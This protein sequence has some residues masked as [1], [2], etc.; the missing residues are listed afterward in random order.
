MWQ[1]SLHL[2]GNS[3]LPCNCSSSDQAARHSFILF[4]V[5]TAQRQNVNCH[6]RG[7]SNLD[8][9]QLVGYHCVISSGFRLHP[10]Y[11]QTDNAT[12]CGSPSGQTNQ[13]LISKKHELISHFIKQPF[14][15]IP[16]LISDW[17]ILASQREDASSGKP[18]I[19][20]FD[21]IKPTSNSQ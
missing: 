10:G 18:E 7:H 3:S 6:Q 5:T 11:K 19:R 16:R 4:Q 9:R 1:V 8:Q 13:R 21:R 15:A 12:L 14:T 2:K 20:V 17:T